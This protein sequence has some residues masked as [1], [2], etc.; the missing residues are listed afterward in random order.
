MKLS[1]T[2]KIIL[3]VGVVC[4]IALAGLVTQYKFINQFDKNEDGK[5]DEW[6]EM[7]FKG[8]KVK[9]QRDKN[10][11]GA[12]DYVENYIDDRIT[13]IEVDFDYDGTFET[14]GNYAKNREVLILLERDTNG[15]GRPDKR[16]VYDSNTGTPQYRENDLDFDGVYDEKKEIGAEAEQKTLK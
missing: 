13:T 12:V 6:M 5:F 10:F 9:F 16:T 3:A 7:N 2:W 8:E 4:L 1:R 14:V 11:D 15:D